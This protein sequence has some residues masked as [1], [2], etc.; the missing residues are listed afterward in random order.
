MGLIKAITAAAGGAM[1]DQW[2][3]YFYCDSLDA[4]VLVAKGRK[5]SSGRGAGNN[6]G[7]DIIFSFI[8]RHQGFSLPYLLHCL[9]IWQAFVYSSVY[10]RKEQVLP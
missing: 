6:K 8:P 9:Y 1:A 2:R 7:D 4:N 5:R 10:A 3:E